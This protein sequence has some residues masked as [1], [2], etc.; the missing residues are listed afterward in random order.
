MMLDRLD[1]SKA[2]K[3]IPYI[4]ILGLALGF[5]SYLMSSDRTLIQKLFIHIITS[6]IIGYSLLIVVFNK[7]YFLHFCKARWQK[8]LV[9]LTIFFLIGAV[10]TEVEEIVKRAILSSEG[11]RM[12][13]GGAMYLFNGIITVVIGFGNFFTFEF[14]DAEKNNIDSSENQSDKESKPIL[15][16]PSKQGENIIL[17]P[18]ENI[19]YFEAYDNYAFV[20]DDKGQKR[21]C[22]YSLRFLETRLDESFVRIHRKHIVN[23]SKIQAVKPHLNSRYIVELNDGIKLTSSKTYAAAIKKLIKL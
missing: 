4:L 18:T 19:L 15:Q 23:K 7:T 20:F 14:L 16:I 21:M 12:F 10:A 11:F 9:L 22:D 5:A 2:N 6:F 1:F 8:Y 13:S 17:T 3:F